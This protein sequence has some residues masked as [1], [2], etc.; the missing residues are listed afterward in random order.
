[1]ITYSTP[2]RAKV[3]ASFANIEKLTGDAQR[4]QIV[5]RENCAAC[6]RFK[7]E[8]RELGPDLA[9]VSSKPVDWLLTA[10]FDPNQA[11]EPRYQAQHATL[12]DG[13]E[14][15]GLISGET[16]NNITL[17]TPDGAEHAVLRTDLQTLR[18]LGKSLMPEGLESVLKPQSVADLVSFLRAAESTQNP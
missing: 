18:P 17:R 16:A 5:F 13:A 12:K 1:V 4:G 9:M 15:I 11:I 7:D 3:M 10:I 8:G 6:H 14:L 2:D